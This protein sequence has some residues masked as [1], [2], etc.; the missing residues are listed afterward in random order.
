[1]KQALTRVVEWFFEP[2]VDTS[3]V[4]EKLT[5]MVAERKIE[6]AEGLYS[7]LRNVKL[8]RDDS[9]VTYDMDE[10]DVVHLLTAHDAK[11]KEFPVVIVYGVD[12]FEKGDDVEEE[13]R[14]LY[15]ALTRAKKALFTTEVCCGKSKFLREMEKEIAVKE[16]LRYG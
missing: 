11:G 3:E 7:L 6:R 4:F 14:V 9:R 12:E 16:D 10:Y 2:L 15:V 1:M 8:F 5:D 13:R